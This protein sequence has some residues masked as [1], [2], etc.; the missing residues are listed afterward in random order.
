MR[1]D[2]AKVIVERPRIKPWNA[3]KGRCMNL[4]DLPSHEGMRRGNAWR[5]DRKELNENLAPLRRYLAKQVSRPWNKVYSEIAAR[6]RVDSA[7]QQHV[8]DHL[9]DFVALAPRMIGVRRTTAAYGGSDFMST[10]LP[11]SCAAP[12]ICLRRR[13]AGAPETTAVHPPLNASPSLTIANCG[14]SA[15][16]GMR[17]GWLLCRSRFTRQANGP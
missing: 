13:R 14:L 5:G 12:I 3:R 8:R 15:A 1:E 11:A 16:F 6:L 9:R 4:D 10:R 7:V 17:C 2:M